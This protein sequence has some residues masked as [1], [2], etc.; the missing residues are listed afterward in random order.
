MFEKGK[1]YTWRLG[2]LFFGLRRCSD[3]TGYTEEG[4]LKRFQIKFVRYGQKTAL[5]M[6]CSN[7]AFWLFIMK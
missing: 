7:W 3:D 5:R 1:L 6:I 2:F 4:V